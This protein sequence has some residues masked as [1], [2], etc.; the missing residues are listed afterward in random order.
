MAAWGCDQR[1]P[2]PGRSAVQQDD[3]SPPF[4]EWKQKG[5]PMTTF[6]KQLRR[7]RKKQHLT[8]VD[9][10][11]AVGVS[12]TYISALESGRKPAPP[13]EIVASMER[14]LDAEQDALWRVARKEREEHL[15]GRLEGRP[16]SVTRRRSARGEPGS[17]YAQTAEEELGEALQSLR[18]AARSP[19][20]EERLIRALESLAKRLLAPPDNGD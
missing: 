19:A 3:V 9:L 11:Q 5:E 14:T 6:A 12:N 2:P 18:D 7:L 20:Q 16:T 10:A 13:Y 17:S 1:H 8:Q 15:L 4:L